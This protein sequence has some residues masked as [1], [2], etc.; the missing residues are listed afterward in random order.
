[1][2]RMAKNKIN[3]WEEVILKKNNKEYNSR[4]NNK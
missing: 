3:L 1:M 4:I 2:A